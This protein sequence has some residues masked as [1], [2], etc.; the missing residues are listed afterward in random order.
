MNNQKK[1]L[2]VLADGFEEIEAV[3]SVDFLRRCGLKVIMVGVGGN[4]IYGS[5]DIP[6]QCDVSDKELNVDD[7]DFDAIILPGGMPGTRNLYNSPFVK[8]VIESAY[9]KEKYIAAICAAPSILG[10]MGLLKGREAI[11][12][13]SFTD[14][15]TGAIISDKKVVVSDKIIT[16]AGPGVALAFSIEL[17]RKLTHGDIVERTIDSL[18]CV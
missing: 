6:I 13:P 12:F 3:T 7:I 5:R 11:S 1:V 14:Q 17:A 16:A 18:Q 8:S 2:V 9:E 15:L 4:I 10:R